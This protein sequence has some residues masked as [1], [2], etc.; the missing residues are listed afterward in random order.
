LSRDHVPY[1]A[2][3]LS[4]ACTTTTPPT[5]RARG[6]ATS[7][8]ASVRTAALIPMVVKEYEVS[9]G[10]VVEFKE[11]WS[12]EARKALE[13]A[14]AFELKARRIELRRIEPDAETK[15]EI[16]DLRLLSEAVNASVPFPGSAFDFSL[17]PVAPLLDRYGADALLF[18]WARSRI[19]SGGR[20]ALAFLSGSGESDAGRVTITL[21]DRS[22]DVVW[23]DSRARLGS[24][25]DLRSTDSAAELVRLLLSDLPPAK[26]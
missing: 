21:V 3:L 9:A 19:P 2:L 14:L 22:G 17:G 15:E 18:V 11:D 20:K 12:T 24:N 16:E 7:R 13:D 25:A 4:M 23:Y 8:L 10:G 1:V 6:D 26:P 5:A